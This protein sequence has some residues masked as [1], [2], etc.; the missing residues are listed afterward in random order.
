[1]ETKKTK[2]QERK[3]KKEPNN[4]YKLPIS[5]VQGRSNETQKTRSKQWE[6]D[7]TSPNRKNSN[8]NPQ[9]NR[10]LKQKTFLKW[11]ITFSKSGYPKQRD[12]RKNQKEEEHPTGVVKRKRK[13]TAINQF[14]FFSFQI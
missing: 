5:S 7:S 8:E 9:S 2:K 6:F 14:S 4:K 12:E 10:K 13:V 1:L 11:N 3:T